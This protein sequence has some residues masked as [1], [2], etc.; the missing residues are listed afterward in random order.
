MIPTDPVQSNSDRR[1]LRRHVRAGGSAHRDYAVSR[2]AASFAVVLLAVGRHDGRRPGEA[3]AARRARHRTRRRRR[4]RRS[5]G[6]RS[7]R[8]GPRDVN[9][10]LPLAASTDES[11]SPGRACA[12]DAPVRAYDVVAINVD[13]TL[14]RYLD[15]DPQ[16]RMYVLEE[17]AG[18][19]C[20]TR[21]RRTRRRARAAAS[22]RVS[23]RPAG[24]RDP[25]ADAA[26]EPGRVPAHHAAQRA[27]RT[28]RRA[29][30]STARACAWPARDAGDRDEPG[31][32]GGARR[33]GDYEWMVAADEPE[34]THYFHSHGD[35]R[36][37]DQPRPVRRGDRRADGL[38]IPRSA[39]A[40]RSCAAAGTRSSTAARGSDFRE[41]ALYYHEIGDE[42][43]QLLDRNGALRAAGRPAHE[44]VPAGRRAR[45]TTAASRS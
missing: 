27:R 31:R 15:H 42:N 12:T 16:G 44:R 29:S 40:A 35:D 36:D 3:G 5:G 45:S 22:R 13:I 33:N 2:I 8:G 38:A 41:F 21:R 34:G 17:D 11:V 10:G 23:H 37:A 43:Y 24:R 20:A 6:A 30:T 4:P 39:S 14:N 26:R 19:A 1:A 32:D 9:D 28:S 18:R 7:L 25:A